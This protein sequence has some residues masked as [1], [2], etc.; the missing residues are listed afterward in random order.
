[1]HVLF[2]GGGTGG[3]VMP[4][5][6]VAQALRRRDAEVRIEFVGTA[7]G[8][9]A[10][11]IPAAGYPFHAV[12]GAQIKGAG[13]FGAIAGAAQAVFGVLGAYGLLGRLR[14]DAVVGSGGYA[15]FA[16]GMAAWMRRIPLIV[17]EANAVPGRAN[18]LLARFADLTVVPVRSA[19]RYLAT[20]R[21]AAWGNPVRP[22]LIDR[23]RELRGDE[24]RETGPMRLFVFGGSQGART[25]NN[26]VTDYAASLGE[27]LG[28]AVEI[29]HQTGAREFEAVHAFYV[30]RD[31]AVDHFA[32]TDDMAAAYAW[33]DVV[34]AR[35]GGSVAE[36]AAVGLPSVL[37]PY[38]FAADDHQRANAEHLAEAGAAIVVD[39][40]DMNGAKLAEIANA[41][42]ADPDKRAAMAHAAAM[43][44]RPHAADYIAQ[45][46]I[47]LA[48]RE[49]RPQ[50]PED[51][52]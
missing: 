31:L 41:L 47:A 30:E 11:K 2:A 16:A 51:V 38:P 10:E 32:F 34:L 39:D 44:G 37:V 25:L 24:H 48:K 52:A 22:E 15:S 12:R 26:A 49:A 9:E 19:A 5:L 45:T 20:K 6:A 14:P 23:V 3:H 29:R 50:F 33:A 35:A 21:V 13:V 40:K 1:M 46:V 17:V 43:L 7:S 18:R 28:R 27:G 4:A 42:A 36:I 8:M